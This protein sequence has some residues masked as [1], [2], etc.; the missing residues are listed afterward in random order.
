[1]SVLAGTAQVF[2]IPLRDP[3]I[4]LIL[5]AAGPP[6]SWNRSVIYQ[7]EGYSLDSDLRELRQGADL[8]ALEAQVFDFLLYLIR[9]RERVISKDDI[10]GAVWNGRIVSESALRRYAYCRGLANARS[11]A[12]TYHVDLREHFPVFAKVKDEYV[13]PPYPAWTA[14][15]VSQLITEG[16]IIEIRVIA[17]RSAARSGQG[18]ANRN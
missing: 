13:A 5:A 9:N 8:V 16:T 15:G 6:I 1:M 2:E 7:F 3:A 12:T 4:L 17:R 11:A 10:I 14:I 18:G